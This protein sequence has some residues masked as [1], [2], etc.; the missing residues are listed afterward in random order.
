MINLTTDLSN[1]RLVMADLMNAAGVRLEGSNGEGG[2]VFVTKQ[3][4]ALTTALINVTPPGD[5][6]KTAAKIKEKWEGKFQQLGTACRDFT[7]P[8]DSKHGAGGDV[9]W[10]A[11][12]ETHLYGVTKACDMTKATAEDLYQ[13]FWKTTGRGMLI[14]GQRGKQKVRIWQKLTVKASTLAKAI[15]RVINHIGRQKA[16]WLPS[17]SVIAAKGGFAASARPPGPWITKHKNGA[18]GDC[19]DELQTA[20]APAFTLINWAVGI[21]KASA[22]VSAALKVRIKAMETDMSLYIRGIKQ[23]HGV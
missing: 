6:S 23:K 9:N 3:A 5:R 10:Y 13:R 15:A 17:Y 11:W 7:P 19:I 8:V 16:G 18:R 20:N 22:H 21:G 1:Y 14:A 12:D 4:G 2:R